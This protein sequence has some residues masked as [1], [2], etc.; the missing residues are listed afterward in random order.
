MID[1][2]DEMID[3]MSIKELKAF[4]GERNIDY[5]GCIEKSE[6]V[7]KAKQFKN[8]APVN[9]SKP[10][11]S[12]PPKEHKNEQPN[13]S[14]V[15]TNQPQYTQ[16]SDSK[17][18]PE[19]DFNKKQKSGPPPGF[20]GK[21]GSPGNPL[22]TD[23]YDIL[24]VKPDASA[25]QIKKGYYRKAMKCHPDKNPSPE[26]EEEFKAVSEAYQVLMDEDTRAAYDRYGKEG[27][28]PAGGFADPAMFF[29]MLF[30][31]G[32]FEDFIGTLGLSS[33]MSDMN[34]EDESNPN[35]ETNLSGFGTSDDPIRKE[36]IKVLTEKLR[37]RLEVWK[38]NS[39]I[40]KELV[41]E[42]VE[43]SYG[44]QLL[45]AI[46]YVY[47]KKASTFIGQN[48]FLGIPGFFSKIGDKA[49]IAKETVSTLKAAVSAASQANE[50]KER[51]TELS[52]EEN[53]FIQEEIL[54]K[55]FH[56][57][58]CLNKLDIEHVLRVACE[59]ILLEAEKPL[60]QRLELAKHLKSLGELF[61]AVS[62]K[63]QQEQLR[64]ERKL[65]SEQRAK[66]KGKKKPS[67]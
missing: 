36:R 17:P 2:T 37:E 6:M 57:M 51:E 66:L 29:S 12:E 32:K 50:I 40:I 47:E 30:G 9:S 56:A 15:Y 16:P 23:Y 62:K 63:K 22:E 25:A 58:W 14:N 4:L 19:I 65:Q 20:K 7:D 44:W 5:S 46:G 24:G 31:G 53:T 48:K 28:E 13:P 60:P 33:A 38:N 35:S 34:E 1:V 8:K 26:A 21:T 49:H 59:N 67:H 41:K 27:L 61:L 10:V 55:T 43:E 54:K 3:K 52:E 39:E 42:L 11:A 64:E 18:S 45:G